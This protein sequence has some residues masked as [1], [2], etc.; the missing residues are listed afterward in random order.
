MF[1]RAKWKYISLSIALC[2]CM[3]YMLIASVVCALKAYSQGGSANIIMLFSVII[4]FGSKFSQQHNIQSSCVTFSLCYQQRDSVRSVTYVDEFPAIYA[5]V[6]DVH[7]YSP[8]VSSA[9]RPWYGI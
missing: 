6:P 5:A 7:Q 9:L 8:D 3:I 4:T 2:V 1:A